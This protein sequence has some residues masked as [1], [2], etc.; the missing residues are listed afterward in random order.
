MSKSRERVGCVELENG[1]PIGDFTAAVRALRELSVNYP[2][3]AE[4][5]IEPLGVAGSI[6]SW[7]SSIDVLIMVVD[8]G[9]GTSDFSLYRMQ[10]N[11]S[12]GDS[13]AIEI[14]DSSR[15]ITEAGNY[16]DRI[17]IEL[18]IKKGG[19][20]SEDPMWVNIRG[21]LELEIRDFKETL[22]NEEQVYVPLRNESVVEVSLGEFLRLKSVILFGENLMSMMV[23]ILESVDKSWVGWINAR[24]DRNLVV[25]LTGGGAELPMVKALTEEPIRVNGTNV[26]VARAVQFPKWLRE[27]DENLESDYPRV[28]VSLGGA[29]KRLIQREGTARVTGGDVTQTPELGGYYQKGGW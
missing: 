20:D 11:D 13:V 27:M 12:S 5:I 16:L 19:V 7:N 6:M 23:Q 28:A 29:R 25:A 26:P 15:T 4:G 3:V 21:A 10:F 24:P 8:I 1:I 22:F 2:F 9:A 18:I 17:L 14:E